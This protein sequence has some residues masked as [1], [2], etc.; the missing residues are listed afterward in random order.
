MTALRAGDFA[1]LV[2]VL[3]P[4]VVVRFEPAAGA[5]GGP[6]EVRGAEKWARGAVAFAHLARVVQPVL[7]NGAV[8]LAHASAGRLSRALTFNIANGKIVAVEILAD[9]ERL[10]QLDLA[11]LGD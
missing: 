6:R 7:I 2:A 8:G 1:G 9:P 11:V 10:E 5:P 4:E 3:D